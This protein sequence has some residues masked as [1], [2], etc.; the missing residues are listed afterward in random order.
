VDWLELQP[1]SC[2]FR[3]PQRVTSRVVHSGLRLKLFPYRLSRRQGVVAV[4]HCQQQHP[5]RWS[6][7]RIFGQRREGQPIFR[8][9]LSPVLPEPGPASGSRSGRRCKHQL[10]V[11]TGRQSLRGMLAGC[12]CSITLRS[13]SSINTSMWGSSS[14]APRRISCAAAGGPG[15]CLCSADQALRAGGIITSQD[16][17]HSTKPTGICLGTRVPHT[18]HPFPAAPTHPSAVFASF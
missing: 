12:Q 16:P 5:L 9:R 17:G 6:P 8:A 11:I 18:Y 1:S 13:G 10:E 3:S 7:G 4:A 14:A 15:W 2:T